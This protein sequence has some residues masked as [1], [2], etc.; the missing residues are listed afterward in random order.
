MKTK[1]STSFSLIP[2]LGIFCLPLLTG[3]ISVGSS[4]PS[5]TVEDQFEKKWKK[6]DYTGKA[7]LYIVCDRK[8]YEY[9]DNWTNKLVPKYRNKIHFV[10]I[11]DVSPVPGFMK[12]YVRGQFKDKFSFSVLLDWQG[13]LVKAF[14]MEAGYPTLVLADKSGIVKYRA[15]GKGSET[16]IKRLQEN[17]DLLVGG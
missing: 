17:I 14:D 12:G 6:S 10:P 13:V 16:Q 7:A 2:L 5:F 3:M 9:A 1:K 8:G 15:W 11:A 4:I